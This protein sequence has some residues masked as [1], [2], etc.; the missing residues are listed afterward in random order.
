VG[1]EVAMTVTEQA[2]AD[3]PEL[4]DVLDPIAAELTT[5]ELQALNAQVDVDGLPEDAV[6][7]KWLQDKGLIG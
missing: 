3:A 4:E 7:E 5:E 1:Y 6:A 2:L